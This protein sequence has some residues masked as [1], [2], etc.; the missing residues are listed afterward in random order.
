[1]SKVKFNSSADLGAALNALPEACEESLALAQARQNQLTKPQGSLGRLE[2]LALWMASWQQREKP[3]LDKPVCLVFAGNHGVSARGVS[4][5]PAEV[6]QQM[7]W[8]FEAGGAAI[9]QLTKLADAELNV[10]SL[11]LDNPTHDFTTS[12]AMSEAECCAA[13]QAGA[14][15]IPYGADLIMLGEMGIGNTTAAA[16]LANAVF[17]G[18]AA[19][20]IGPG[21]GVGAEGLEIKRETVTKAIELHKASQTSAF[22]CLRTVG[23]REL[24]AI[25]GAVVEARHR[26]IPVLLDGYISTAAASALTRDNPASLDHALIS[27]ASQEPGHKRLVEHLDKRPVLDLDMRLGE[28]S[29]AAVALLIVRAALATH[30]GMSTFGE[31]GVSTAS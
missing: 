22:E 28:A 9:N 1:M 12:A 26:G 4:A 3:V 18:T 24:A 21:T 5:Y 20:W 19:D 14:D 11:E 2:E 29:G 30:N 6:T 17:G 27:H 15:A 10:I 25:A 23:G 8:N 13:L 31:A 7:V 16:A